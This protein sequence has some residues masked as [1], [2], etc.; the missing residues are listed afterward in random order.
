M[1]CPWLIA[2][3]FDFLIKDHSNMDRLPTEIIWNT[4]VSTLIA[5]LKYSRLTLEIAD[6]KEPKKFPLFRESIVRRFLW[7]KFVSF[8][9]VPLHFILTCLLFE[10]I[11]KLSVMLAGRLMYV[12]I[13]YAFLIQMLISDESCKFLRVGRFIV[14]FRRFQL[15]RL[16]PW[17]MHWERI[18]RRCVFGRCCMQV[19]LYVS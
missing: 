2:T 1:I 19:F 14:L 8:C 12:F 16:L 5:G 18:W 3:I 10:I 9:V 11:S 15:Q 17:S 7:S 13:V 6:S 4:T